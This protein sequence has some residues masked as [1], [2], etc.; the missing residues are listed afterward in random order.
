MWQCPKCGESIDGVPAACPRCGCRPEGTEAS[1]R[2][3]GSTSDRPK[4]RTDPSLTDDTRVLEVYSAATATEAHLLKDRLAAEGIHAQVV[5]ETLQSAAGGLPLGETLAPRV[6]VLQADEARAR[7]IIRHELVRGDV[8]SSE[9]A[10]DLEEATE[11]DRTDDA[12][13]EDVSSAPGYISGAVGFAVFL[14]VTL[15]FVALLWSYL[16]ALDDPNTHYNCGVG[17]FNDGELEDAI[18]SFDKAI[19]LDSRHAPSYAAR[20]A[21]RL[22]KDD[23]ENA[24]VDLDMAIEIDPTFGGFY[25]WRGLAHKTLGA[26]AEAIADYREAIQMA[27]Q[28]PWPRGALAW[29]MATCPDAEFRDGKKAMGLA[30]LARRLAH[31]EDWLVLDTLAAA[32]AE[33]GEFEEAIRWQER[34]IPLAPENK[35]AACEDR[36]DLYRARKPYREE[37]LPARFR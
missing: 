30:R 7:A 6:W 26:Y 27:P 32:C 24:I 4:P 11:E 3:P 13:P 35:K 21:A 9:D 1:S 12:C 25:S 33:V 19:A 5:G 22:E 37:P 36:L 34:V 28:D 31:S 8:E 20:G 23:P 18:A 10:D 29:L 17:Y 15:P 14:V 16:K 2:A